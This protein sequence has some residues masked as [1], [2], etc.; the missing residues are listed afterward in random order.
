MATRTR[1]LTLREPTIIACSPYLIEQ[2]ATMRIRTVLRTWGNNE[3]VIHT[4]LLDQMGV[5]SFIDGRYVQFKP[6]E[7]GNKKEA[8]VHAWRRFVARSNDRIDGSYPWHELAIV[9]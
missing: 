5:R 6:D 7:E 1:G 2:G 3:F 4:E 8:L 9:E